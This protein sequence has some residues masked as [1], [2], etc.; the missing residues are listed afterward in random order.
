MW[1]GRFT[2]RPD[3]IMQAINVSIDVDKRLWQQDLAGS[4]AHC[5]MLA[6]QGNKITEH[7]QTILTGL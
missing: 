5:A 6:K 7:T 4:K 1:G 2:A 3:E